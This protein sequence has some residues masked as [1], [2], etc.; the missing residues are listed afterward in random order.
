MDIIT[1]DS[2][3]QSVNKSQL[4]RGV[5]AHTR[6]HLNIKIRTAYK[7][8]HCVICGQSQDTTV[9][10]CLLCVCYLFVSKVWINIRDTHCHL[11]VD[12]AETSNAH[13]VCYLFLDE[14]KA[15][16]SVH[17][18][19]CLWT[20]RRQCVSA[21]TA[22]CLRIVESRCKNAQKCV[23]SS[24]LFPDRCLGFTILGEI[25]AYVTVF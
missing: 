2:F 12:K 13:T 22:I 5:S 6:R 8:T 25:F 11:S 23:S 4:K 17:T 14:A 9:C 16:V 18:V 20:K 7:C 3:R 1:T 21:Q 19:I 10:K 15:I 24:S